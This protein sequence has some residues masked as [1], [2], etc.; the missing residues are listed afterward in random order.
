[1]SSTTRIICWTITLVGALLCPACQSTS[2]GRDV[3]KPGYSW[4]Q[5][6]SSIALLS[7]EQTVWQFNY[8]KQE[9]RPYFHPL[10][11][12]DGT[13]LTSLRPEDHRWHRA[14]WFS[15]KY[16]NGPDPAGITQHRLK[17]ASATTPLKNL[18]CSPK[19][20]PLR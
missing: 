19:D 13:E 2:F 12:T 18:P 4:R 17:C 1:M 10:S 9:G 20:E 15:W 5:T 8:R 3:A 7:S 14:L 6:D 11:L 16:I